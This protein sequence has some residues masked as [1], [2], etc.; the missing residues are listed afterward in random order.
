M[1]VSDTEITTLRIKWLKVRAACAYSGI[2]RAKLYQL[3]AE[4]QIK[5]ISVRK[6][7]NTRGLRL[8]SAESI[9]TFL[10]SFASA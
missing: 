5:S 2:S 8:I 4:G 9:D 1:N 7:G 10:D 6:K 3:M